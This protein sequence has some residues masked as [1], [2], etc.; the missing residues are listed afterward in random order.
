MSL[1]NIPSRNNDTAR[2]KT[3]LARCSLQ[4]TVQN[5]VKVKA[6]KS[7]LGTIA[8]IISLVRDT[9]EH[10]DDSELIT[11]EERLK[12][13]IDKAI[14][15]GIIA[16][17]TETSGLNAYIDEIAGVCLY[18][19]TEKPAYIPINHISYI[20]NE[21]LDNQLDKKVVANQLKRLKNVKKV[22]HN[23]IF[24][25]TVL[26]Y[27]LDVLVDCEHDT[28]IA[29]RLLNENEEANNLKFLHKKY[30]TGESNEV[31]TYNKL[32]EGIPFQLIPPDVGCFY[33]SYDALMTYELYEFQKEFLTIGNEKCKWRKLER[34]ADLFKKVEIPLL[35]VVAEMMDRGFNFDMD[36]AYELLDKYTKLKEE[37]YT[38]YAEECFKIKNKID[39]YRANYNSEKLDYPINSNS[40]K[41]L[42][43]LIYDILKLKP[44]LTSKHRGKERPT[45]KEIL[46]QFDLPLFKYLQEVKQYDKLISTYIKAVIEKAKEYDGRIHCSFQTLWADTGRTS[47]KKPNLQNLGSKNKDIRTMYIPTDGYVLI[48]ADYSQQEMMALASIAD[49]GIMLKAFSEGKDIY[50]SVA[51]LA[52]HRTYE[53]CMEK[54]PDGTDYPEGK[55]YRDK[56]KQMCLSIVY[57]KSTKEIANDL[58]CTFEEAVEIK[59]AVLKAHPKLANYLDWVIEF[60][61]KNGY[62]ESFFGRR[63]R[64][65]NLQLPPYEYTLVDDD[66]PTRQY[67][68]RVVKQ[69]LKAKTF[70][71]KNA[72]KDKAY[73]YGV[74]ITDN[75]GFIADAKRQ[76]WNA[77]IQGT[78]SD[79]TKKAMIL[80]YNDK[81]MNEINA[82]L[83]MNIHDELLIEAPKEY[84]NE[85]RELL[86]SNMVLAGKELKAQ[87]R[88]DSLITDRWFGKELSEEDLYAE[89]LEDD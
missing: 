46:K 30:I 42:A 64:L 18:T 85:A 54:H 20:T 26:K 89:D 40:P 32:F 52:F 38:K 59:N 47:C 63:R 41:Q 33:A 22:W 39:A 74:L 72:I 68:D 57:G 49:E 88:C 37:A 51:S 13:Y 11:T 24:D 43:V 66:E 6:G 83:L 86:V 12:E 60:C 81:R 2:D 17:D 79:L 50:S 4:E 45:D 58:K 76:A 75:N 87:L 15:N 16:I 67:A 14:K 10:K 23:Y 62:V 53:E 84:A 70:N 80:I 9:F 29:C 48:G 1:F 35:D 77:P 55:S 28:G 31:M 19:P 73:Q 21:K 5:Q 71:E 69:L 7:L 61:K 27:Q 8:R 25:R 78:A 36:R 3:L 65:P 44:T 56:A 34:V 82:H